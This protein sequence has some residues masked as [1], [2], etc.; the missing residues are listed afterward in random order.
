[1]KPEISWWKTKPKFNPT[2]LPLCEPRELIH[3]WVSK[4]RCLLFFH[5]YL[6]DGCKSYNNA[7]MTKWHV[8]FECSFSNVSTYLQPKRFLWLTCIYWLD[9][10]CYNVVTI[11]LQPQKVSLID[12]HILVRFALLETYNVVRIWWIEVDIL[13]CKRCNI[14]RNILS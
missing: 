4:G 7:S 6:L 13:P 14:S 10:H 8:D 12:L 3:C 2:G 11:V 1:M 9:L 5:N